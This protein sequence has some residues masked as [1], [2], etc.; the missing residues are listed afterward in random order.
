MSKANE[1]KFSGAYIGLAPYIVLLFLF[2]RGCYRKLVTLH[3]ER[4]EPCNEAWRVKRAMPKD[5]L[6]VYVA[7]YIV[8]HV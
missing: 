8:I 1:S 2:F 5:C 7:P 6:P 4:S 3:G